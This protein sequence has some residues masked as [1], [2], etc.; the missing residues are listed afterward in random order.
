MRVPTANAPFLHYITPITAFI[1]TAE[2]QLSF[3][4]KAMSLE[5]L[6]NLPFRGF[7]VSYLPAGLCVS[8]VA[9]VLGDPAV[10]GRQ[11]DFRLL[12]GLHG[13]ADQSGV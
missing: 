5:M 1:I 3:I 13:H 12:A 9:E 11:S 7:V 6:Q 8:V 4:R 10:D 2:N